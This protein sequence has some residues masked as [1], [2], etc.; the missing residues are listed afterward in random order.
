[1]VKI[2]DAME[3]HKKDI[4]LYLE[5]RVKFEDHRGGT[6]LKPKIKNRFKKKR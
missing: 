2:Q 6:K 5:E 1:M 3:K 4:S